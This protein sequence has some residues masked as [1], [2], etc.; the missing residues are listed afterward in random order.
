MILLITNNLESSD[1]L[2][3]G[4][5]G[6]GHLGQA[7]ARSLVGQG[8]EKKNLLLSYRGSPLTYQKLESQGL[9]S[10]VTSN[11]RIFREAGIVLIT[12]KPQ[13]LPVLKETFVPG[14]ALIVSCM[15]GVSIELLYRILNADVYRMMF[16]GPDTIASG[17]GVAAMYPEHEY[18]KSLLRRINLTHVKIMT[19]NDLD[20]F[21]AGVCMPA[22]LL[23]AEDLI[24]RQK[25]VDRIG[26]E[27]PMLPEL[28]KWAVE[29]LPS[30]QNDAD[31]EAYVGRMITKGGVT[32]AVI[33]SLTDGA[34]L[35]V[36]L[37]EGIDR[38]KE[39]SKEIQRSVAGYTLENRGGKPYG[40]RSVK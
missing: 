30:F 29:I 12:I 9:S 23:K 10:C 15:A 37:Q 27:Y 17:K 6:C 28:Y 21:T 11:Q 19:E 39:I 33:N 40:I 1:D 13:D 3:V 18:L 32:E 34:T 8:F 5:V 24:E 35:D 22:A 2:K 4:I 25:A 16:S 7:I 20:I 36:A 38:T 14:K 26:A 31:K